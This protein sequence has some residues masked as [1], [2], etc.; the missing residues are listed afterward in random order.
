MMTSRFASCRCRSS[1]TPE[2]VKIDASE[3]LLPPLVEA[4][5][6]IQNRAEELRSVARVG[7][8]QPAP[9]RG[10]AASMR[11]KSWT[12]RWDRVQLALE[13]VDRALEEEG[14]PR[15]PMTCGLCSG[16]ITAGEIHTFHGE[17]YAEQLT[18]KTDIRSLK[19]ALSTSMIPGHPA[20]ELALALPDAVPRQEMP[21]LAVALMELIRLRS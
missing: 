1:L 14:I 7:P 5:A 15:S 12:E 18:A 8:E 6:R 19:R 3:C 2:G 4:F 21:G 20:R 13:A 10:T 17:C 16:A 11:A 9:K